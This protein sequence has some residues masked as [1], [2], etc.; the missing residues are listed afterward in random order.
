MAYRW[1]EFIWLLAAGCLGFLPVPAQA[2]TK[3]EPP[4][5][6]IPDSRKPDF[7]N[8]IQPLFGH[9][10]YGCHGEKKKGDLD[11]RIYVDESLALRDRQVFE[12]V[13]TKLQAHE[14][15]PENKPQP[16]PA[17]R[18]L[19]TNWVTSC[20]FRCDCKHPDPG[21]VT[22]RRLNRV[23]YNNT[24]HDLIGVDFQ[25]AADFPADD[26]GYGF[27]NIG[28]VLS[29]SPVL[30]EKYLN[31][32]E[33]ILTAALGTNGTNGAGGSVQAS[34]AYQRIMICAPNSAKKLECARQII[35]HFARRAFRRPV[36]AEELERLLALFKS[37]DAAGE[38]FDDG[39][40]LTLEAVLLSPH[41]LFR[42]E[43]QPGR[44]DPRD[45]RPV[46]EYSLASRLSYFLWSTM[47]DEELFTQAA[48]RTLRRN[49]EKQVKRMLDDPKA[50]ALVENF[51][52]QWLQLSNLKL[53]SPDAKLFPAFDDALRAAMQKETVGQEA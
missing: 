6:S 16:T 34:T 33:R 46:D 31:A 2:A 35:S 50:K 18:Q 12:K 48:H 13:L 49:L 27:D 9:Y 24:I 14:M 22:I 26:S 44:N 51:A 30:M 21:R 52:S 36:S 28:D 39:I 45:V 7:A 25:P 53:A 40:K 19:L 29:V 47:P 42:G 10:C 1:V 43:L 20:F 38:T 15:P 11:L 37:T 41:F 5:T 32:A 17:Q 4:A 23:E 8:E 3:G